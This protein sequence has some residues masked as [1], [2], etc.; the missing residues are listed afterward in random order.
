MRLNLSGLLSALSLAILF[1]TPG[2]GQEFRA[3][4]TGHVVDPSSAAVPGAVVQIRNLGTNEAATAITDAQGNYTILFLK[5]GSYSM[6][7]EAKGFK[8]VTQE[9]FTLN[10]GQA[11]TLNLTLEVGAVT[12]TL[13]VNAEVPL[14]ESAN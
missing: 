13:T 10:V 5:P 8:K 1:A 9:N 14:I 7:A 11:A 2:S 3:T 12:E 6:V 4:V